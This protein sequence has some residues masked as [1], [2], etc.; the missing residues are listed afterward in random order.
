[1][2]LKKKIFRK[3]V[4]LIQ[5]ILL[6]LQLYNHHHNLILEHFLPKPLVHSSPEPVP[7]GNYKFFK[8]CESVSVLQ[9][10]SRIGS[11]KRGLNFKISSKTSKKNREKMLSYQMNE[12]GMDDWIR[13]ISIE[14]AGIKRECCKFHSRNLII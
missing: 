2:K 1:M 3:L 4:F 7:F 11:L 5:W 12:S 10:S 6:Y 9:I 14:I 13:D 8:V